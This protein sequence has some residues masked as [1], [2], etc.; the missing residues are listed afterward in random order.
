MTEPTTEPGGEPTAGSWVWEKLKEL[1]I[2]KLPDLLAWLWRGS[3]QGQPGI[4][5]LGP[6]GVGKTT[7]ARILAGEHDILHAPPGDYRESLGV[8]RYQLSDDDRV[9]IVVPPGQQHRRGAWSDLQADVAAGKFRGVI[10]LS[11]YG[12]HT[13][14]PISYKQHKLYR[15][16]KDAFRE[17]YLQDRRADE[18]SILQQ[19]T[20]YLKANSK[21]LWLLSL[22]GKQDLWWRQHGE[23]ER[24][25]R[26][27]PYGAEITQVK[28]HHGHR[29]FRHELAF[30]SLLIS[31]LRDGKGDVLWPNAE[32][33]DQQQRAESTLRLLEALA[34][35]QEWETAI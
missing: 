14:G 1:V 30:A 13:F 17:A 7:L 8:E 35:L 20:P 6:G 25:Y 34:A 15:N 22:V 9:E 10:L 12:Y 31:N 28:A 18:L 3:E 16:D 24:H 19:L 2:K 4:L 29:E 21:K 23:V 11:A 32:G 26:D 27:G 5:I 33:Y